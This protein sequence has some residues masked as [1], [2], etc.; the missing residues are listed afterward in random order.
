MKYLLLLMTIASLVISWLLPNHY[1]PWLASHSEFMAF[2]SALF[3][4]LFFVNNYKDVKIPVIFLGFLILAIVPIIQYLLGVIYFFGDA[5]LPLVYICAFFVV[6]TIGYNIAKDLTIKKRIFIGFCYAV[7]FSSI[8][9]VYVSLQQW[10]LLTTGSIWVAEIPLNG[11]PFGNFGQPNTLATL[12]MLGVI[13]S[14]YLHEKFIINKLVL[15]IV[16]TYLVVGIALTQSRTVWIAFP[17]L[18]IL[19]IWYGRFT[20]FRFNAINVS[21]LSIFYLLF[22][23]GLPDL[24]NLLGLTSITS[25]SERL[26]TGH[27]RFYLWQQLILAVMEKPIIGYGWGQVSVAQVEITPV[28]GFTEWVTH[29]HNIVIDFLVWLGIPLGFFVLTLGVLFIGQIILSVRFKDSIFALMMVL[30][31]LNHALF[32]FPLEYSFFLLPV[33]FLLG[34]SQQ[35]KDGLIEISL[36]RN[37]VSLVF[38][39]SVCLFFYIFQEYRTIEKD[40]QLARFELLNI[41]NVSARQAAPDVVFLTQL[42]EQVRFMR[43]QPRANMTERQLEWMHQVAYRYATQAALFR[44]AQAL[45]LNDHLELAKKQLLIIEKLY[46]KRIPEESL[47]VVRQS[48]AFEWESSSSNSVHSIGNKDE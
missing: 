11:M 20:D 42:S 3:L 23:M 45:A 10:L 46:G 44:Y 12:L 6:L 36:N 4:I 18:I 5:F 2:L 25:M 15:I 7:L 41:G 30:I 48:L 29:S 35:D 32:E 27:N 13:C 34:F 17:L 39:I 37:F 22:L 1:V 16:L 9:S 33:G 47:Y 31:V 43:T 19:F 8:I 14:I 24:S 38:M 40:V 26:T 28:Y 21:I